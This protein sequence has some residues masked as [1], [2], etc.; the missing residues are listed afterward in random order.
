CPF[1]SRS[2][3]PDRNPV[4]AADPCRA[5]S[6]NARPRP[7]LD[8]RSNQEMT[9]HRT[10]ARRRLFERFEICN[11]IVSLPRVHQS[12]ERHAGA[13][14]GGLRRRNERVERLLV[15]NNVRIFHGLAVAESWRGPGVSAYD[16]GQAGSNAIAFALRMTEGALGKFPFALGSVTGAIGGPNG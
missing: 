7:T 6:T 14:S 9:Q 4:R 8:R 3:P 10:S 2:P 13:R 11:Q 16:S 12:G 1:S 5:D 15:P